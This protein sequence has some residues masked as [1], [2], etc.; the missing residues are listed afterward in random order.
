M[1]PALPEGWTWRRPAAPEDDAPEVFALVAACNEAVI[2]MADWTLDDAVEE[3]SEPSFDLNTDAWLVL[4]PTGTVAGYAAVRAE[5]GADHVEA[6]VYALE[7]TVTAWLH[8]QVTDRADE[9]ARAAG[10]STATL[11]FAIY[12]QDDRRRDQVAARGHTIVTTFHRMRIDHDG[13]DPMTAPPLPPGVELR[14]GP[15]DESFRRVAHEVKNAGFAEHFGWVDLPFERWQD[16]VD[17]SPVRTWEQLW[18]VEVDGVPAAMLHANDGFLADEGCGYVS[19]LAVLPEFRGRG[20]AKLLLQSAFA[21]DAARGRAGTILHVDT[22]NPT[23]ALDLY[24][25][26]GMRPVLVIDAWRRP[27]S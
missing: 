1:T 18:L 10:Q 24:L 20:L 4:D 27:G 26:L 2:G 7:D 15:G 13:P 14:T 5:E 3:L 22:N 6:E 21:A 16:Q 9:I 11:D 8:V 17:A 12:R 19:H 23:P 25:S